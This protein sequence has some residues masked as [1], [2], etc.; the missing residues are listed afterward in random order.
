MRDVGIL[1]T[2]YFSKANEC[3]GKRIAICRRLPAWA[4]KGTHYDE[5]NL[6]LAPSAELLDSYKRKEIDDETYEEK[7][8]AELG[9]NTKGLNYIRGLLDNGENIT[10]LCWEAPY[11]KYGEKQYCHRDTVRKIFIN[12]NYL[13]IEIFDTKLTLEVQKSVLNFMRNGSEE[14]LVYESCYVNEITEILA[15][16]KK[17][18]FYNE[19]TMNT[20]FKIKTIY[21][22]VGGSRSFCNYPLLEKTLDKVISK[23]G[24]NSKGY[25]II[26][27]EG[28]ANGA[29]T[30][31][32]Y[33][34]IYHKYKYKEMPADWYNLDVTPCV[35]GI[36]NGKEYNKLAG[37]IRNEDM[38]KIANY[39][40]LFHKDNSP[41]TADDIKLAKKYNIE[42]EYIKC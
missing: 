5:W 39:M 36:K 4:I 25:K 34:A 17:V 24:W 15:K 42:L 38:A 18:D 10:L 11:D 20:L 30:L 7:Y 1:Y 6:N 35:I 12:N 37:F 22:F 41:G 27:V 16:A 29:D 33:Y 40:V 13:A 23:H 19:I 21:L 31:A 9:K 28:G 8:L 32:R 2:N 14:S 3:I 26:I